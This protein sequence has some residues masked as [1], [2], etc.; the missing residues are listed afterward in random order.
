MQL[1]Q[2][3]KEAIFQMMQE[4][5]IHIPDIHKQQPV[6][7]YLTGGAAIH[8]YSNKRVS[9]DIDLIIQ[10]V[11]NIPSDLF[12]VWQNE[13]GLLEEVHYDHTYN[14]SLGLLQEDYEDR[15]E[16]LLS[17]DDK[18]ETYLFSPEDLI[19][20]KLLTVCTK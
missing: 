19:I 3:F 18:F 16:Y 10:S 7:A 2:S 9:D 4:I 1:A 6:R 13:E 15:A 12:V 17:I 5:A 14:A 8:F 11:V 20:S